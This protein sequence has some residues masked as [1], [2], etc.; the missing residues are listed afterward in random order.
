M[1]L[2]EITYNLCQRKYKTPND[3]K[4]M[5][6]SINGVFSVP[7][8]ILDRGSTI[9]RA[10]IINEISEVHGIERLS[11]VPPQ[12]NTEY[13]RASTPNHTMF[14]GI[15]GD[16]HENMVQACLFETCECFREFNAPLKDYKVI[17]SK[18]KNQKELTLSQIINIDGH[19]KSKDFSN[20]NEYIQFLS[21]LGLAK[22]EIIQ[23]WRFINSEFTKEVHKGQ[24]REY[25]VSAVFTEWLT[26]NQFN[27]NGVIYES[28]QAKDPK[29]EEI[30]CIALTPNT[31]DNYMEF[32][33]ADFYEFSFK[34]VDNTIILNKPIEINI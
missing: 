33:H 28:V 13:K 11:Y 26:S 15:L 4:V 30:H 17:I 16:T 7:N 12:Y 25:W 5:L 9:Y 31:V 21:P 23:F 22:D 27:Y 19:N 24:E 10:T 2:K 29:L 8:L 14:Y 1:K 20:F 3:I 34:G 6:E 32:V 18:W